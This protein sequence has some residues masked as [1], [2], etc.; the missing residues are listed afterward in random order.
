[1]L[2]IH[3]LTAGDGYLYLI[4]QV[5]ASD[6]THRGRTTLADYYSSK[7]ET[8]G[9]WMGRGLAAL[10]CPVS[11]DPNDPMVAKYWSVPEGSEVLESQMKSLFGEGL[12]PNAEKIAE[13][14]LDRG[15]AIAAEAVRLGRP[16]RVDAGE[17]AFK[18]RLREAYSAYNISVDADRF[19]EI[20]EAIRAEIRS[21]AAREMFAEEHGRTPQDA[22]ELSG[23]IARQ[24]RSTTRAVAGF[25]LTFTP[26]KTIAVLW[27][28]APRALA[29][30]IEEAHRRSVQKAIDFLEEHA[31]FT[32][33]GPGAAAQVDVAGLIIAAFE[34]RDS[35]AGDPNLHTHITVSNKV[36]AV[37][38]D[39]IPRWLALDG[40]ALYRAIVAASE[41][42][43]TAMEGAMGELGCRFVGTD[44]GNGK[45][46][47]REIAGVPAELSARFSSRR[48]AIEARL[49]ELA[50][51]FQNEHGR[52]PTLAESLALSQQATLETRAAKH[53]PRSLGEQRQT[54]RTQ[55]VEILG[56][57]REVDAM[58]AA[59]SSHRAIRPPVLDDSAV[60][61]LAAAVIE[62]VSASRAT[63]KLHHVRA[64][65][66]RQIRYA[67]RA[68]D[69]EAVERIVAV[70]LGEQ[71]VA[72]ARQ[73][74]AERGEP[75]VLRRRDGSS[76]YTRHGETVYSSAAV[77]TAERKILAAAE[78]G[79]GRT[80][81]END[82][83]LALLE[84]E[85][86]G[87]VLNDG[88][89]ALVREMASSGSRVQLAVAPAGTGKT[90]ATAALAAAWR[91]SGGTIVGLAPTAAAAEVLAGELGSATDTIAKLVQL[92]RPDPA[93]PG[94]ADDS[95]RVWFDAIDTSTLVVIDEAGKASTAELDTVIS[96]ALTRGASVRLI[97]DDHQLASVSAG[98]VL[99]DLAAH[100]NT[101]TL[102][103]VVRF[104]DTERGRAEA[105][106]SLAL[107]SGDPAG[108]AFYLDHQ[109][110]H[111]GADALA[112][113]MAYQA[114]RT[115]LAA[116]RASVLLAPTNALVTE[117]N[118]RARADRLAA[119]RSKVGRTVTLDDGLTASVGDWIAT[120]SNARW[121]RSGDRT[122][123]KN[124]HRWI[125]RAVE[126]DGSLTVAS[127]GG[128]PDAVVR[129]PAHYVAAHT[130]LGY[131]ATIDTRQ[132][133]TADTCHVVGS[134]Q[135]SRQHLYVALT[136]G[137]R[138]NHLYFSIAE[139]DPHRILTPKAIHPPTAV[140]ILTGILR[141]DR[142]PQSAHGAARVAADPFTRLGPAAAMYLDA[143]GAAA[144]QTAGTETM[145]QIDKAARRLDAGVTDCEAWPVLRR[146]LALLALEGQD[147]VA[148]LE[149]AA[150]AGDLS[151]ARAPAAVLDWRLPNTTP[152][153]GPLFWLDPIP[154]PLA[155]DP[156]WGRYLSA[157][158]DLVADLAA[159]V[160]DT[161]H[162]WD[163]ATVPAWGRPLVNH[164]RVLAE[165]AVF[166]AA[167]GV[168]PADTRTT[169]PQQYA[170]RSARAQ[171][172]ILNRVNEALPLSDPGT[173]RWRD[174]AETCDRRIV[175]DPYWTQLAAHLDDLSVGGADVDALLKRAMDA[176]PLPDELPAAA[177]WWRL[178]GARFPAAQRTAHAAQ[179]ETG[180]QTKTLDLRFDT[181]P[182][183][184]LGGTAARPVLNGAELADIR[185][186][187]DAARAAVAAL[188]E[189]IFTGG[190][191]P[192]E[193]AATAE[194][195]SL[196][197]RHIE[198]RP[199]QHRLAHAR[200][201]WMAAEHTHDQHHRM[202]DHLDK[203]TETAQSLGDE[204]LAGIYCRYREELGRHTASVVRRRSFCRTEYQDADRALLAMAG[205]PNGI[206]TDDDIEQRRRQAIDADLASLRQARLDARELD[207][208]LYRA[209]AAAA[210]AFAAAAPAPDNVASQQPVKVEYDASADLDQLRAEVA[211]L[212]IAGT[213]SPAT[214][215]DHEVGDISDA[216][217]AS[218]VASIA[219]SDMS[220]QPIRMMA[221]I[222]KH[223]VLRGVA[224][225]AHRSRATV[226]ALP[227]SE[228]AAAFALDH[229]YSHHSEPADEAVARLQRE[230]WNT[231][232]GDLVIVDDA[233]HL[234]AEQ[235]QALISRAGPMNTKLLLVVSPETPS[236]QN[237]HLVDALV[238]N[239]PWA[240]NGD[241]AVAAEAT[242]L[243]RVTEWLNSGHH[244]RTEIEQAAGALV[245]RRDD[246]IEAYREVAAPKKWRSVSIEPIAR[247]V[248]LGL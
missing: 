15:P 206:V 2:S 72:V 202:L 34:H 91:N 100:H 157:R 244:L 17:N 240:V 177:L 70:A 151:D 39:G 22:R 248:G 10:G 164:S 208:Q 181:D 180:S 225:A 65:A 159:Q 178:A 89:R 80:V 122:W 238:D 146:H 42:Y 25:D 169:G 12:H 141:R 81:D 74:D 241:H 148:A 52:E 189:A 58:V 94:C 35:R 57:V 143:L 3:K 11:R 231:R 1:M 166:R 98:G 174:L 237:R 140:D 96:L 43:N 23:F 125:I 46:C 38:P 88:Q 77:L 71:S 29:R 87:R 73:H 28:L 53:E 130:A 154:A 145:N 200:T 128:D 213:R 147:P 167:H 228:S 112:A 153:S 33:M 4:R 156:R 214:L 107:R 199:Y 232:R 203:Q 97:G 170:N 204:A 104:G 67:H 84:A 184:D 86:N 119:T 245:A 227:C 129:L 64:E 47:V 229:R 61:R 195:V 168:D 236:G 205:G 121:L 60:D 54:W 216:E 20:P 182:A 242:A 210:R 6:D 19:A 217:L 85:A 175:A 48:V 191:G 176:G 116:G 99:R 235:L 163:A 220:V 138:E 21:A 59:V 93:R 218:V 247:D 132:G 9:R 171:K 185:C 215:Y 55:A 131:A 133:V 106:A 109:R 31:A 192:A 117:L 223:A 186:R 239:L 63:W 224:L 136:R 135:L 139:S 113:A 103:E 142:A 78:L 127:L 193:Q 219:D 24:S 18:R 183:G 101:L 123:V 188:E 149:T 27:A 198:Q 16:F 212:A 5:A 82:V 83:A 137:R 8:P 66:E 62:R 92:S 90:T 7:G 30:K 162:Q 187:R 40:A 233:D 179:R 115:A 172:A 222:D 79:G 32:R 120:R 196:H 50:K 68:G 95:A 75:S 201:D 37:G 118:E 144:E 102:S 207:N 211:I 150:A 69:S 230:E 194:L 49:G 197:R 114:W 226:H 36:C 160:R 209:E 124:G 105:A 173:R 134:D 190:G 76:V 152:G 158:A 44:R 161:A 13:M 56:G 126:A 221:G 243:G 234:S 41:V 111:V 155:A 108:I 51:A 26:V 45:R 165:I 14:L 110:V 246:L